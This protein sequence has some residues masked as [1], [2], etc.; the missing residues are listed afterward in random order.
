MI[1]AIRVKDEV[2]TS[3]PRPTPGEDAL[4]LEYLHLPAFRWA[5]FGP[6]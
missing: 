1:W 6:V 4:Q 3:V 5:R 2:R